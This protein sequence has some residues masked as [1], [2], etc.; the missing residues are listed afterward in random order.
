MGVSADM[1]RASRGGPVVR[2]VGH[3]ALVAKPVLF[4]LYADND[5]YAFYAGDNAYAFLHANTDADAC[6]RINLFVE[7]LKY[8]ILLN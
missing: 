3:M 7:I 4:R 1:G 6:F 5:T 2:G 8:F